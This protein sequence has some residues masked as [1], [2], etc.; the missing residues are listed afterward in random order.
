MHSDLVIGIAN[1]LDPSLLKEP[2]H[3]AVLSGADPMTGHC[4]VASE[5]AYHILGGK[6]TGWTPMFVSHEGS[7]HW[8]LRGP[9]GS[10]VDITASQFR[11]PVPY[12]KAKAKGFLTKQ[13]S[14][15]AQTVIDRVM[16]NEAALHD[17]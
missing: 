14:K 4:Y 10:V 1:V 12:G 8:F 7:P 15:R 9:G 5:A 13:P 3:S 2:Y 17:E 6:A 11:T 16:A